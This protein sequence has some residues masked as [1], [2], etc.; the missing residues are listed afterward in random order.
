MQ[1]TR[2]NVRTSSTNLAYAPI[3]WELHQHNLKVHDADGI[4]SPF[5]Q[6]CII[7][8]FLV[9]YIFELLTCIFTQLSETVFR[10]SYIQ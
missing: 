4:T 2:H 8:P 10:I 1:L 6:T 7:G 3:V 9:L 5:L